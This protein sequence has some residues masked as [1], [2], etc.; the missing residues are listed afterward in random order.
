MV[1]LTENRW[2]NNS[3]RPTGFIPD[4]WSHTFDSDGNTFTA[5]GYMLYFDS[6]GTR[7]GDRRY[8]GKYSP[9]NDEEKFQL[10]WNRGIHLGFW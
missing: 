4:A 10:E 1:M 9:V 3:P 7:D 6:E 5:P 8:E 2:T